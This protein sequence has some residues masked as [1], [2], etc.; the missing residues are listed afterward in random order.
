MTS[1]KWDIHGMH[2]TGIE[3]EQYDNMSGVW[4]WGNT[5]DR[6][7]KSGIDRQLFWKNEGLTSMKHSCSAL[8]YPPFGLQVSYI[9]YMP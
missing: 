7:S 3:D 8:Q 6:V 2:I 9:M 5:S 4:K 1:S